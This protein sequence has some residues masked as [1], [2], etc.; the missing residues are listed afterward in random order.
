MNNQDNST[1]RY[2]H[3]Y[4]NDTWYHVNNYWAAIRLMRDLETFVPLI[5]DDCY[6]NFRAYFDK[7][8]S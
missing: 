6:Y 3:F 4:F 5:N 1:P 2:F 7:Q 8:V